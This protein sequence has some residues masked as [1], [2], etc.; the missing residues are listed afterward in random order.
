MVPLTDC[1]PWTAEGREEWKKRKY[2][3]L[4]KNIQLTRRSK[5]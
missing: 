4:F 2:Q 3:N 5:L 1:F